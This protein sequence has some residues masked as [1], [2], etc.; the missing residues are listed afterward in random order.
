MRSSAVREDVVAE[1]EA[2]LG[3]VPV[4]GGDVFEEVVA[5]GLDGFAGGDDVLAGDG[6]GQFVAVEF[7]VGGEV[8]EGF[9]GGVVGMRRE[10]GFVCR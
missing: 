8:G 6:E 9:D 7:G 2:R 1:L 4:D 3:G 5:G 10:D